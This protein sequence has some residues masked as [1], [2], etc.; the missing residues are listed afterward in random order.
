MSEISDEHLKK[1]TKVASIIRRCEETLA[2]GSREKAFQSPVHLSIGQELISAALSCFFDNDLGDRI[3][4]NHRSHG[5][6]LAVTEDVTGLIHEVF[7][8]H[9]GCSR[10]LGGS[11]HISKPELGFE[12]TVPIVSGTIPLAVGSALFLKENSETGVSIA[13]FGDGAVE[14]GVFH[15]SL[16]LASLWN[17]PILFLCENNVFSSHMHI[18]ERQLSNE[19]V[20]F[21]A[22]NQISS[23]RVNGN[24]VNEVYSAMRT[25]F[26]FIREQRMPYF[27]ECN[28]YRLRA[29]VGPT[30]DLEIGLNRAIDL[31]KYE[32]NDV[33]EKIRTMAKERL[34]ELELEKNDHSVESMINSAVASAKKFRGSFDLGETY[35]YLDYKNGN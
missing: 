16:N 31:P 13:A 29:H 6:Y 20:R 9:L 8:G 32:K 22:S 7:G 21:G 1:L 24:D 11:M 3:F 17:L 27:L 2:D 4:G 18:T 30:R 26:S 34:G 5:H 28:T 19:M 15:E 25:A 10:N 12:G 33:L 35:K 23:C 14:E